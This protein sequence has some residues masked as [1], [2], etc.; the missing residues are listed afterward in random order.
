MSDRDRLDEELAIMEERASEPPSIRKH[1]LEEPIRLLCKRAAVSVDA[2]QS[3][4][5][6]VRAM[7][8]NRFGSVLVMD[9]ATL[10]GIVTERDVLYKVAGQDP[11]VLKGP[12]TE[13]MTPSP[14]TLHAGDSIVFLMNKMHVGGFRH[15]PIVDDDGA[16]ST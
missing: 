5:D 7:Q 8:E 1:V 15:I 14:E 3:A 12:V 4:R 11:A 13:I 6:A 16:P 2:S 10:V 9:G